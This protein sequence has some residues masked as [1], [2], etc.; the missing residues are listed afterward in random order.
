[1]CCLPYRSGKVEEFIHNN[2]G[3]VIRS[4]SVGV[5]VSLPTGRQIAMVAIGTTVL[6]AMGKV[7]MDGGDE[8]AKR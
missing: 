5:M 6:E 1:M 8:K 4:T 7:V 3:A 2:P